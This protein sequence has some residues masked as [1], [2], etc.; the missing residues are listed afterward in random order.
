M[1]EK[2]TS[3]VPIIVAVI[4]VAGTVS[5]ALIANWDK[6]SPGRTA[7]SP[8]TQQIAQQNAEVSKPAGT[9]VAERPMTSAGVV[10]VAGTWSEADGHTYIF[11]QNGSRY[12]FRQF[13]NDVQVGSGTGTLDGR[14]FHHDFT[15]AYGDGTCDGEVA[16][17]GHTS[18]GTCL[19]GAQRYEMK[20]FRVASAKE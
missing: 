8:T 4:G 20:V 15:S 10:D 9:R 19:I 5:A 1:A 14:R 6:L 17:D 3:N 16:A 11:E 2:S 12:S 13:K 7:N 18:A